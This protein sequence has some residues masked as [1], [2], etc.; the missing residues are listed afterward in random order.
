MCGC[1]ASVLAGNMSVS[2]S[3]WWARGVKFSLKSPECDISFWLA[4]GVKF[5]LVG[6]GCEVLSGGPGV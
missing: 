1:R 4:W 6:L 5:V 2:G 3:L